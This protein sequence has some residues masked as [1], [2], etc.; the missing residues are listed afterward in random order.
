VGGIVLTGHGG[1][2]ADIDGTTRG[3]ELFVGISAFIVGVTLWAPGA[4]SFVKSDREVRELSAEPAFAP[5]PR[6]F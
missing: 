6:G 3:T 1:G 5:P 2:A 4:A